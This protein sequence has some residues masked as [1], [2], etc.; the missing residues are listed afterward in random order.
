MTTQPIKKAQ[1]VKPVSD[2]QNLIEALLAFQSLQVSAKKDGS[3][4]HFRSS[5]STLEEVIK[6][7]GQ[8]NQFGL[9]YS[10]LIDF[11]TDEHGNVHRYVKT[12][13]MHKS[14]GDP[15][16]SR[17]PIVAKD[18]SNPHNLGSGIT[19]AKRYSLQG[20][21]GLPSEDDDAN[22]AVNSNSKG[23]SNNGWR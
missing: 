4:P 2:P 6:A 12:I 22:Q 7:V 18:V 20:I 14:G 10:Q 9:T 21:Y 17:C 16:V 19:Y 8:G 11:A 3:N 13:L 5:Y 15:L 1:A 23:E